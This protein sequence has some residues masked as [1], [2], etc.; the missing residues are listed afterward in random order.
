MR[1]LL[2]FATKLIFENEPIYMGTERVIEES[3]VE[4][5]QKEYDDF[6]EEEIID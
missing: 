1:I 2:D 3:A 5:A 4:A 6:L